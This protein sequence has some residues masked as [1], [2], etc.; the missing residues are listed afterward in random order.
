MHSKWSS[1]FLWRGRYPR[2]GS[3]HAWDPL[4]N[5]CRTST[6]SALGRMQCLVFTGYQAV[7]SPS[8]GR[9]LNCRPSALKGL[10]SQRKLSCKFKYYNN[11]HFYRTCNFKSSITYTLSFDSVGK[12]LAFH[13]AGEDTKDK[14][15]I[16]DHIAISELRSPDFKVS[17]YLINL[18]SS[19]GHRNELVLCLDQV[20]DV[21]TMWKWV[22]LSLV[23]SL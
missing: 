11:S 18:L 10:I 2:W 9:N 19:S 15:F 1:H 5:F 16:R 23:Q 8:S 6:C 3:Q 4:G 17:F 12:Q 14:L 22:W 13:F 21:P 7:L 20:W